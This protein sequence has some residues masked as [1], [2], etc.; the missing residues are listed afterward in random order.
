MGLSLP[1]DWLN[2]VSTPVLDEG[3]V[4]DTRTASTPPEWEQGFPV[5]WAR[6]WEGYKMQALLESLSPNTIRTYGDGIKGFALASGLL[7]PTADIATMHQALK[8]FLVHLIQSK[9]QNTARNRFTGLV[10]FFKYLVAEGVILKSPMT[11]IPRPKAHE[12]NQQLPS[13]ALVSA[14]LNGSSGASFK[15]VRDHA[16][17]HIL[18]DCPC[19]AG[20]LLSMTVLGVDLGAL[21]ARAFFKFD[22]VGTIPYTQETAQAIQR[23][24]RE[25]DKHPHVRERALWIG[26]RGPLTVSGLRQMLQERTVDCGFDDHVFTHLF[27]HLTATMWVVKE[28]SD[29]ALMAA[30]GWEDP[31]SIKRY[32]KTGWDLRAASEV[33]RLKLSSEF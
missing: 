28:G 26:E 25:R 22:K 21:T 20:S 18:L 7:A 31:R 13:M 5:G 12:P 16:I 24:L 15:D 30:G 1:A 14:L 19:R 33:R 17:L 9:Q 29:L 2:Q 4:L 6:H 10:S 32:T 8:V 11:G 27:R 23:Y 3:R